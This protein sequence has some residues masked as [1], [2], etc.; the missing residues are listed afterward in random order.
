MFGWQSR[1]CATIFLMLYVLLMLVLMSP[2][3]AK[4]FEV[5]SDHF[6]LYTD[7]SEMKGRRLLADLENRVDAFS[8]AFGKVPPRQFPIEV[9]LF[10][11]DQDFYEA[12]PP[13]KADPNVVTVQQQQ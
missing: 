7:T 9:F 11:E 12:L 3:E 8:Q 2:K 4:W 13:V 5:S 1:L 10:K 6:L